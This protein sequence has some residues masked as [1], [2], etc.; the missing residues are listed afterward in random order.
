MTIFNNCEPDL[1]GEKLLFDRLPP[2]LTVFD[3]GSRYDSLFFEYPREVHYFE[4][5]QRFIEEFRMK[6]MVLGNFVISL[7]LVWFR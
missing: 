3:V 2:G 4:P 7:V 1:N 6:L 5:D